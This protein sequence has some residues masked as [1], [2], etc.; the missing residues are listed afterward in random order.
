MESEIERLKDFFLKIVDSLEDHLRVTRLRKNH[1]MMQLR[2]EIKKIPLS[3]GQYYHDHTSK[4]F[5]A[6]SILELIECLS[7]LWDYLNPGLLDSFVE[8]FGS[9]DIKRLMSEYLRELEEF[10]MRVKIS[11]YL[12]AIPR[13]GGGYTHRLQSFQ[14]IIT[15]MGKDWEEQTLQDVEE[16]KIELAEKLYI[17]TFLLH[18]L[19]IHSS[20]VFSIP[21][22]MP[23]DFVELKPFF[24]HKGVIKVSLND[25]CLIDWTKE[26][27]M[28]GPT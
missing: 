21:H 10:R 9:D 25:C 24:H 2:E 17:Q 19:P 11:D 22:W 12:Q 1:S 27:S 8:K 23:I 26:V 5:K 4:I 15:Q 18:T 3:P 7:W 28:L 14:K 13:Q 20:I 6:E 16:Y